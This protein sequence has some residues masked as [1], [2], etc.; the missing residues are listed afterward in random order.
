MD[1]ENAVDE[2]NLTDLVIESIVVSAASVVGFVGS[3]MVMS[4]VA[5]KVAE[6]RNKSKN[7][8]EE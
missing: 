5:D 4:I 7:N 3:L 8:D 2:K 1:N 6:R